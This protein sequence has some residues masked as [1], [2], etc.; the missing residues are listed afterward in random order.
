M[1]MTDFHVSLQVSIEED[2]GY[3][4]PFATHRQ[5]HDNGNQQMLQQAAL[6]FNLP[7]SRD[8]LKRFTDTLY[9]TQVKQDG[10]RSR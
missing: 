6:H 10:V 9:I 4:S 2:W 3:N 1:K 7:N 5:H 8:P